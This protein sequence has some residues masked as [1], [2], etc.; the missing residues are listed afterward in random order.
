MKSL[1]YTS[2]L[3]FFLFISVNASCDGDDANQS[4]S[5]CKNQG[6]NCCFIIVNYKVKRTKD[7]EEIKKCCDIT[8]VSSCV[9][10]IE[11]GIDKEKNEDIRHIIQCDSNSSNY[12]RL[13][14]L[15]LIILF[16]MIVC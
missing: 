2:L 1:L 11:G 13:D 12:L 3:S 5:N 7:V 16:Y 10:S 14:L 15:V 9:S 6:S 4:Y 8:S